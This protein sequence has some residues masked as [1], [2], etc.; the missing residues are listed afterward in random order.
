MT[1]LVFY[2]T[3]DETEEIDQPGS[4]FALQ[5]FWCVLEYQNSR[6]SSTMVKVIGKDYTDIPRVLAF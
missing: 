5:Q 3:L 4:S 6:F 1:F 2:V